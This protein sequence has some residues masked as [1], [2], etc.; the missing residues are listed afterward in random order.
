VVK[1]EGCDYRIPIKKIIKWLQNHE[2]VVSELAKDVFENE[3]ES[4]GTN[5]TSIYPVKIKLTN[6]IPELLPTDGRKVKVYNRGLQK[7]CTRCFGN[8][9]RSNCTEEKVWWLDNV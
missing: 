4:E 2:E 1:I 8:H 3:E 7:L 5:A 6:S 9:I